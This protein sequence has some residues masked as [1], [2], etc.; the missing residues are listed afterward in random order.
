MTSA[1]T[2][3]CRQ[4][5]DITAVDVSQ[6]LEANQ[7]SAVIRFT[8]SGDLYVANALALQINSKGADL[9]VLKSAA[10]TFAEIGEEIPYNIKITNTGTVPALNVTVTDALPARI[11]ADAGFDK[12]QRDA[13]S[14]Q[15]SRRH[16]G[17][18][19]R[20]KRNR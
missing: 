8:S 5:R 2:Q 15:L 14:R 11:N 1:N 18:S 19:R 20:A 12:S 4:G 9:K 3:A 10:K 13:L 7:F 16:C 17:N 6:S